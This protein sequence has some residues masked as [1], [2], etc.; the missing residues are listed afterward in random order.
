MALRNKSVTVLGAGISGLTAAIA[1]ARLG[2]NVTV[3]DRAKKNL[4]TGAGIQISPNG[5]GVMNALGLEEALASKGNVLEYINV[6][7][8]KKP[9][10]SARVDLRN[11]SHGNVHPHM[12]IHRFDLINIL[13][14]TAVKL[15]V[16]ILFHKQATDITDARESVK[17]K[18][19]VDNI[20]ILKNG[21]AIITDELAS[22][23]MTSIGACRNRPGWRG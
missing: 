9:S 20:A 13:I 1:M 22:H 17:I 2:S 15:G 11:V 23:A 10:F 21:V 8:Y 19:S 6:Q 16:K 14:K 18:F 12:A 4:N 7:N 3:F 5:F